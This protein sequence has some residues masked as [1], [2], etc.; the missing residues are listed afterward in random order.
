[1]SGKGSARRMSSDASKYA[2]GW[3]RVFG[4]KRAKRDPGP[5]KGTSSQTKANTPKYDIVNI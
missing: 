5:G 1:M 2:A 3:D 4:R